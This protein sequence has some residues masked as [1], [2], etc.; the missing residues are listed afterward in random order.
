MKPEWGSFYLERNL[1]RTS[2]RPY[3]SCVVLNCPPFTLFLFFLGNSFE[4]I[5]SG[6]YVS[7]NANV[8]LRWKLEIEWWGGGELSHRV[9]VLRIVSVVCLWAYIH[10]SEWMYVSICVLKLVLRFSFTRHLHRYLLTAPLFL[11]SSC[12]IKGELSSGECQPSSQTLEVHPSLFNLRVSLLFLLQN[13][14]SL[15]ELSRFLSLYFLSSFLTVFVWT[16][17]LLSCF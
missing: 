5:V 6:Y 2:E 7:T 10:I 17:S 12:C 1:G 9:Y 14:G 15:L 13:R 4:D 11:L 16:S 8:Q 3:P